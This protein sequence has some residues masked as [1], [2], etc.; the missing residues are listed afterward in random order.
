MK[1]NSQFFSD[2]VNIIL[3]MFKY[4]LSVMKYYYLIV[5]NVTSWKKQ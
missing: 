3:N 4:E 1:R 5:T 2:K